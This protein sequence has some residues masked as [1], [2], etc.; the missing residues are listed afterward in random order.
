MAG[1][2]DEEEEFPTALTVPFPYETPYNVQRELMSAILSALQQCDNYDDAPS[3]DNSSPCKLI[4]IKDDNKTKRR[5]APIIMVESPTGTGKSLSLAC[6]SMSW[7]KYCE[8]ADI[9]KLIL[10]TSSKDDD[11]VEVKTTVSPSPT[12][13]SHNN[14]EKSKVKKYDWIEAWQPTNI[15]ND[16]PKE[17]CT[18]EQVKNA[19]PPSTTTTTDASS[20]SASTSKEKEVVVVVKKEEQITNFATQNRNAL[21]VELLNIRN[22]LDRLVTIATFAT[23]E[24]TNGNSEKKKND[25]KKGR[26]MKV[27]SIRENLVKGSVSSAIAKER[28]KSRQ[29]AKSG[30]NKKRKTATNASSSS[31]KISRVEDEF[32]VDAYHS[33]D[34]ARNSSRKSGDVSSDSEEE[35]SLTDLA[36]KKKKEQSKGSDK[37]HAIQLSNKALLEG[38]NLDGSGYYND[39]EYNATRRVI[40]R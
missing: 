8:G 32:L 18:D 10:S 33:D 30:N 5:R 26:D 38:S 20:P 40:K 31:S 6:A 12:S 29:L 28:K 23:N 17:R 7:L 34:E 13:S 3:C 16:T 19:P 14:K 37:Q 25:D 9:D 39:P 2:K 27:R 21:N 36:N 4:N 1:A 11:K 35:T 15:D 22:R 24:S